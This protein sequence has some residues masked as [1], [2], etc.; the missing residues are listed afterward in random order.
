MHYTGH[1]HGD[2]N[3]CVPYSADDVMVIPS[4][5]HNLPITGLEVSA[6]GT[7]FVAFNAGGLPDIMDKPVKGAL[8]EPFE[9]AFLA[10]AIKWVLEDPQRRHQLGADA[11]ARS[12]QLWSP[13]RIAQL[14]TEIYETVIKGSLRKCSSV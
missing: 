14:H 12:E 11:R 1:L 7:P 10:S 5:Q 8:A 2:L 6:C 9:P 13:S 4:R 3:L